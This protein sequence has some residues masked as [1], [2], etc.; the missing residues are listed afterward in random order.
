MPA[1]NEALAGDTLTV[2]TINYQWRKI[3]AAAIDGYLNQSAR[4]EQSLDN[5]DMLYQFYE[6]LYSYEV[7]G[8]TVATK[9]KHFE[10]AADLTT[11]ST[12]FVTLADVSFS[13][14]ITKKNCEVRWTVFLVNSGAN[15]SYIRPLVSGVQGADSTIGRNN[16]TTGRTTIAVDRFENLSLG[17]KTFELQMRASSGTARINSTFNVICEIYEYD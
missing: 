10:L 1:H 9:T 14:A 3:I 4:D 15:N 12:S 8:S 13:H 17:S 2:L 16:G 7:V 5:I 11:N 6:D